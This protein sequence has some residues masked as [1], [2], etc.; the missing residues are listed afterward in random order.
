MEN[1]IRDLL[2]SENFA[3]GILTIH[4]ARDPTIKEKQPNSGRGSAQEEEQ[5]GMDGE[6]E[7]LEI[8]DD[9]F[10]RFSLTK[11]N[12]T[13]FGLSFFFEVLKDL[14]ISK[15]FIETLYR[16]IIKIARTKLKPLHTLPEMPQ[17]D[18][19][20]NEPSEEARALAQRQIDEVARLNADIEKHNEE[21][22]KIQSKVRIAFRPMQDV[23]GRGECALMRVNNFREAKLDETA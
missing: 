21:V 11:A 22:S 2:V 23:V 3:E 13:D 8:D 10:M 4:L 20:G 15:E 12:I 6:V 9:A 7:R 17:A 18:A 19:E 16:V 5:K 1:F 14:V